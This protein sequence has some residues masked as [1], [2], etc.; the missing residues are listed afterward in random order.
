MICVRVAILMTPVDWLSIDE[1]TQLLVIV[2][3]RL[4]VVSH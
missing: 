3:D 4:R 2:A 1:R